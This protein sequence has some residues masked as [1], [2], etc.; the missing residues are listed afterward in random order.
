MPGE[1]EGAS[2]T[3]AWI[4]ST[5]YTEF[6][7]KS[8]I[9]HKGKCILVTP[10]Y[11]CLSSKGLFE[12]SKCVSAGPLSSSLHLLDELQA[13]QT[14]HVQNPECFSLLGPRSGPSNCPLDY[15]SQKLRAILVSSCF[16]AIYLSCLPDLNISQ[17]VSFP[18]HPIIYCNKSRS[19][20]LWADLPVSQ[21][22]SVLSSC[23]VILFRILWFRTYSATRPAPLQQGVQHH[24][25]CPSPLSIPGTCHILRPQGLCTCCS[26][27]LDAFPFFFTYLTSC[28]S[29]YLST[30]T[31]SSGKPSL[32]WLSSVT[33][34]PITG[35]FSLSTLS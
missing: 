34:G 12:D 13:P 3:W 26:L 32:T 29:S 5:H 6:I 35:W 10:V 27:C 8:Q 9:A 18:F 17:P 15:T 22:Q 1:I 31:T 25:L 24:P 30:D 2:A 11:L 14:Q 20:F 23:S 33:G 4:K 19:A 16:L 21:E 28:H 7:N